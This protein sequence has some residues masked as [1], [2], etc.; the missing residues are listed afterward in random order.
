MKC[1]NDELKKDL[2]I[3]FRNYK[4]QPKIF[5][6]KISSLCS[7]NNKL[8]ARLIDLKKQLEENAKKETLL[9]NSK[10]DNQNFMGSLQL[11][12]SQIETMVKQLEEKNK[13]YSDLFM[14]MAEIKAENVLHETERESL[15]FFMKEL[16]KRSFN[17]ENLY[18][19]AFSA[20]S[21]RDK[22]CIKEILQEL[23]I[24]L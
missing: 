18:N 23:S 12:T 2:R 10:Q 3:I 13:Q 16:L 9:K 19:F 1:T 24:I 7:E 8:K 20:I 15:L 17:R 4:K 14:K 11:K 5:E 22:D 6:R 21:E